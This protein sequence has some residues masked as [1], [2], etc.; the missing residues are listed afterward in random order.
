VAVFAP[1]LPEGGLSELFDRT[2]RYQADRPSPFS[3]WGQHGALDPVQVAVQVLAA[4]LALLVF[5]L[6]RRRDACQVAA[7]G[8][9]VLIAFQLGMT[10]WFYLYVPWFAPLAL[11][12][13]T[14]R[15]AT[16]PPG[17]PPPVG[18]E[19]GATRPPVVA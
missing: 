3:I 12:A 7:L 15:W 2:V 13:L 4:A 17:R 8:A 16:G 1:F 9:A 19:A 14:A 18:A 10:H 11:V 5:F 6:P